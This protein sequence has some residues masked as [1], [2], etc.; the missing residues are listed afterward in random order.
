[1][2]DSKTLCRVFA[3]A[4]PPLVP[5][6][7]PLPRWEA[8][9][10]I[11]R[12]L[13]LPYE[14]CSLATPLCGGTTT[15]ALLCATY[16]I[17]V[18]RSF[19]LPP[20]AG[21]VPRSGQGGALLHRPPGRFAC[22]PSGESPVVKVFFILRRRRHHNLR[23][24]GASNFRILGAKATSNLRALT[25]AGRTSFEP[26]EPARLRRPNLL[27]VVNTCHCTYD[28]KTKSRYRSTGIFLHIGRGSPDMEELV[29]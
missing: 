19:V 10:T 7:P 5:T 2:A 16:E 15:R 8:C 11:L 1:M 17:V 14:S 23:A 9:H 21:E 27:P 3:V 25:P 28:S 20:L 13:T 12:S 24:I 4:F 22:F 29:F 6:A 18:S 26:S